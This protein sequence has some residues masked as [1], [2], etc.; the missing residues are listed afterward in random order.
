MRRDPTAL[1]AACFDLVVV[2]G[3]ITG[4][5]IARDAALR[6]LR[7][8]LLEKDD[9]AHATTAASSKLIHGGLRYLQNLEIGFVRQGLRE[10]RAWSNIA[11]HMVHPLPFLIPTTGRGVK[12]RA[13]MHLALSA[14]DVLAY[15]RNRLDDP[16]KAIPAHGNLGREEAIAL[17]PGLAALDITGAMRFHDCQMHAPERLALECVLDAAR[18]GACVLNQA[19]VAAFLREGDAV[20]GVA[21]RDRA[22]PG[23]PFEARARLVVN[24][25]GPWADLLLGGLADRPPARRLI[26]SKG[27]HLVTRA[28]TRD[29]AIAVQTAAGHFFLLPWRGHTLIGTTDT[30]FEGD[31]DRVDV[32]E[33][34]IRAFLAVVNA[35][36]PAARLAREDVL[37]FYG[38]LRPIV[39]TEGGGGGCGGGDGDGAYGASRAAEVYDHAVEG[40]G[41]LI[42]AIG[43]KWTTSRAL[44]EEVVD[45]ALVKLGLPKRPCPT[46][47]T[48]THGGHTGPLDA[49]LAAA[50]AAAPGHPPETVAHLVGQ[51]GSAHGAVI[52]IAAEDPALARPLGPGAP[53]I[54]AQVAHAARHEMA[55]HL[56]DVLFRRTGIG[57]LGPPAP[58]VVDR[59]VAIMAAE[60]G[61]DA[62]AQAAE[63][64]RIAPH[65]RARPESSGAAVAR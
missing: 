11:P 23:A 61:W 37:H 31:P 3:G 38:G 65:Y 24:A 12:K 2:G 35:G 43:G 25:S 10:R 56:D 33:A 47:T 5:C 9:F 49:Y 48:P 40:V 30:L 55:L 34:E 14:Y 16:G 26:R 13:I 58:A 53:D 52:A 54:G 42:T 45:R 32:T 8:A 59:C 36:Y 19:E 29:H 62:A 28:I 18:A 44:A 27:I 20:R 60:L 63:R 50:V 57:T 46:A 7:V 1:R 6:G 41:G 51:Y 22:H 21:V 39:D 64:A 15:D 17:E 4:A